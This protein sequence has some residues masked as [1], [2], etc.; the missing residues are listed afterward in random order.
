[1]L[2]NVFLKTLRDQRHSQFF[3]GIGLL[4]LALYTT[5]F[6]PMVRDMPE[7]NRL[8]ENAPEGMMEALLGGPILD[9]TTPVGYMNSQFFFMMIPLLFIVF[10][11]GHG[12]GAIAGEEER[13]TLEFLLSNPLPRRS[14]VIQ[15]FGVM[16]TC[17]LT[18]AVVLMLGLVIGILIVDMEISIWRLFQAAL[19]SVALGMV[20][21][22]LALFLGCW[23]G[24]RS[25]S[26]GATSGLAVLTYF[27]NSLGGLVNILRDYRFLSPFYHN[28]EPNPLQNGLDFHVLV[29]VGLV[30]VF[31]ILSMPVFERR[32]LTV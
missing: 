31:L 3:W 12:A 2:K 29:L 5:L 19:S 11:I 23:R 4:A 10:G 14:V 25:L 24:S 28:L 8:L 15:K 7:L 1:M 13:G 17:L 9:F 26:I 6:Y 20:F 30:I 22:S 32:D 27:L 16:V 21:G 18:M